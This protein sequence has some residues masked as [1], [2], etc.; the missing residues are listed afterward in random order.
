MAMTETL[1]QLDVN[2][3]ALVSMVNLEG[4]MRRRLQDLGLIP[5][6]KVTCTQKSPSGSPMAFMVRDTVYALRNEDSD[7][8]EVTVD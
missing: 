3:T 1:T 8:I 5:G 6:T 7:L 2:Q 4:T